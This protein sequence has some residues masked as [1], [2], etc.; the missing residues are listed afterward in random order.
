MSSDGKGD[1]S[2]VAAAMIEILFSSAGYSL[3]SKSNHSAP[4][5]PCLYANV[6]M[7]VGSAR[8]CKR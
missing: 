2:V 4:V 3:Q 8:L 7:H 5:P 1:I 6:N